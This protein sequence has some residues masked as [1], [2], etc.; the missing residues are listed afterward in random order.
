MILSKNERVKTTKK[1]GEY[2]VEY[3]SR[4]HLE[5]IFQKHGSVWPHVWKHC[6]VNVLI[7]LW[8]HYYLHDKLNDWGF[9]MTGKGHSLMA[10]VVSFLVVTR[11][12]LALAQYKEAR[13]NLS[14]MLTA[15]RDLVAATAIHTKDDQTLPAKEWRNQIA[16]YSCL[17]LRL[18]MAASDYNSEQIA[19]WNVPELH[20]DIKEELLRHNQ[21]MRYSK[22]AHAKR[23]ERD[24]VYRVPVT[25]CHHL[26]I[27]LTDS[28]KCL[29]NDYSGLS[30]SRFN[31]ILD[32]FNHAYC[33][34]KRIYVTPPPF[35]M[36]QMSR[37]VTFI[38][39]Y[40]LPFALVMDESSVLAH[41]VIV[42][43][44][45]FA[46]IGLEAVA[47]EVDD[48]FGHDGKSF[49]VASIRILPING[50]ARF[51]I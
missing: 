48:P 10:V 51:A 19:P 30:M 25:M 1:A 23:T 46:F 12:N 32:Q 20:G 47:I 42:F 26:R 22:W 4:N 28:K 8:S 34:Q 17:L 45:T 24:E 27:A 16:Y 15:T 49:L 31:G 13:T 50:I 29:Q 3:D 6:L 7:T 9:K 37:T 18:A 43:V 36:V 39:V 5:V 33:A 38:W 41:C 14:N 2:T 35:P 40:F 11:V 44:V 21:I